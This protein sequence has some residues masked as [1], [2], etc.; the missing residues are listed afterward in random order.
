MDA[1]QHRHPV[2]IRTA[3]GKTFTG[4]LTEVGVD[5]AKV[6]T[7]EGLV[8]VALHYIESVGTEADD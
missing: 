4:V 7:D 3:A 1:E 8:D 2:Q 6:Q 5:F